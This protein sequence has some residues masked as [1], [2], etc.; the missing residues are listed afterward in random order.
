MTTRKSVEELS[1]ILAGPEIEVSD[2]KQVEIR[3]KLAGLPADKRFAAISRA[4]ARGDDTTV[5][6]VLGSDRLL[7]DF[8]GD[9][10]FEAIA[11]FGQHRVMQRKFCFW[12]NANRT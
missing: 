6:A 1:K 8:L 10:E 5:A 7:T 11:R 2:V 12:R 3:L 9:G 4:I